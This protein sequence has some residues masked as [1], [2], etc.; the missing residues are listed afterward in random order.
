MDN[1]FYLAREDNEEV[2]IPTNQQRLLWTRGKKMLICNDIEQFTRMKSSFSLRASIQER[3]EEENLKLLMLKTQTLIFGPAVVLMLSCLICLSRTALGIS[4]VFFYYTRNASSV[5]SSVI[6]E[7]QI[8]FFWWG[9]Y[10][11]KSII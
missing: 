5:N 10:K 11:K 1:K 3:K 2:N 9:E 6:T 8:L 7:Q 4:T